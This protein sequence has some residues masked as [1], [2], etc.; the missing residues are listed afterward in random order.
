MT[1]EEFLD[2]VAFREQ[3]GVEFKNARARTDRNFLE[4]VRAVLGMANRRD[5]G[6]ILIGV[7]DD[8]TID[9]LAEAQI[10]TWSSPDHVRQALAAYA[11]PY[12]FVDVNLVTL[13]ATHGDSTCVVVRVH[14][15][16]EVPVLCAKAARDTN[17]QEILR[18]GACYVRSRQLPA[19]TEIAD[20][21]A[22]RELLDLAI[23]KGV[24]EYVRRGRAAGLHPD[25]LS[26]EEK[27]KAQR[28]DAFDE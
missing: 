25:T 11:D 15:F 7:R 8:G 17:G 28:A 26:D 13:D 24:R 12:V 19:T 21:A 9:G 4:V 18:L 5:G 22:F 20:H 2:L 27:F 3:P 10:A 16:D 23:G 6:R 1:Q 14:E